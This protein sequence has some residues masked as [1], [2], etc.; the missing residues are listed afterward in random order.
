MK[1]FEAHYAKDRAKEPAEDLKPIIETLRKAGRT[2]HSLT[3]D[4]NN[5]IFKG[6][7]DG[8]GNSNT[9]S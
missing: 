3:E 8:T 1:T 6:T 5:W 9:D 7:I 4:N 2:P